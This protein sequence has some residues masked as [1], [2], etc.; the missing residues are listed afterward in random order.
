MFDFS[1]W[2]APVTAEREAAQDL[3]PGT[4]DVQPL[5]PARG[6]VRAIR[7]RAYADRDY[8]N[9][10]MRWQTKFRGQID[11]INRVVQPVFNVRFE[12]EKL[13][14]W[15]RGHTG[16]AME[17]VLTELEALD[18]ATEVE[19]VVG[20]VTP[21]RGVAT[22][23]HEIGWTRLLGRHFVMRAMDDEQEGRALDEAFRL[24]SPDERGRVY[25]ERKSHKEIVIFLHEW[26]HTLGSQHA[27]DRTLIMN[28]AYH[29]KQIAFT[30]F[31]KQIMA[32]VLERRLAQ[33]EQ[34]YPESAELLAMLES[35][36]VF[37]G[38]PKDRERIVGLLRQRI[39]GKASTSTAPGA[40]GDVAAMPTLNI[41]GPDIEAFNRAVNASNDNRPGEAWG[42]LAPL[43]KK[44]ARVAEVPLLACYLVAGHA[45]AAAAR[46]ACD[47]A[48]KLTP[49]DPG[50][51]L[52]AAG[53]YARAKDHA[54][55]APL[56]LAASERARA[57][58]ADAKTWLRVAQVLHGVG[59]LTQAETALAR[60]DL[61]ASD[62]MKLGETI[63]TTRRRIALPR[64]AATTGV[65][66]D[67]EPGYVAAFW[68]A[69][70]VVADKKQPEARAHLTALG[71]TYPEA[72]GVDVLWCEL[73][74]RAAKP[75]PAAKRCA[76]GLAK[77]DEAARAHFLMGVMAIGGRREAVAEKHL[78]QAIL[79]DPTEPGGWRELVR[80][81]RTTRAKARLAE[82]S[83]KYTAL[84]SKPL[85]E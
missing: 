75:A 7:L 54:Q 14:E 84:F 38:T 47:A 34:S 69:A 28:P 52:D 13:R 26:G 48:A 70:G 57:G 50:P 61:K 27:E 18:P 6:P 76:A 40:T 21:F 29:P 20:L 60:A 15:D 80:L 43:I 33:P 30:E 37:E 64:N 85:P 19:W 45:E 23:I 83:A 56:A 41:P 66:V 46:A 82:L 9:V 62:A 74:L 71:E 16:V 81:Y 78:R 22:S 10:V 1:T 25:S 32:L 49:A 73:E 17:T 4:L 8:R 36:K 51:L 42:L 79:L 63:E 35:S 72:P 24:L 65:P 58:K 77:Y 5:A 44:H 12:I 3:L 59:A 11:R 55:A 39:S 68:E 67:K 31:E 53:T 2:K